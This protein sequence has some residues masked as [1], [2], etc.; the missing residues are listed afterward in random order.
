VL[1]LAGGGDVVERTARAKAEPEFVKFPILVIDHSIADDLPRLI[2][3]GASD[4][5]IGNVADDVLV[6]KVRRLVKR[7]R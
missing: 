4:V 2:R 5:V 7:K 6:Q 3:A 1:V